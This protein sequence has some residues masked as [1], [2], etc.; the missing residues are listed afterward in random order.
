MFFNQLTA[1]NTI[2]GEA[3]SNKT[4]ANNNLLYYQDIIVVTLAFYPARTAC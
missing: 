3:G 2:T 1:G 4:F